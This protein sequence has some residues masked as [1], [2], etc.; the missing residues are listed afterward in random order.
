MSGSHTPGT[1]FPGPVADAVREAVGATF[2]S[3]CGSAP[4]PSTSSDATR[5]CLVGFI[6][7]VGDIEWTLGLVLPEDTAPLLAA[8]FA[9]FEI[10]FDSP[11]MGDVI[12]ELANVL[13]GDVRARLEGKRLKTTMSLP[14]L[15][16]GQGAE[17]FAD[18]GQPSARLSFT[19]GAGMFWCEL[20]VGKP[21][22]VMR[23]PG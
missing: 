14:C 21:S 5:C 15:A 23:M 16:R 4:T 2:A 1:A 19:T 11:D 20:V 17:L 18:H 13:A 7:F 9:G 8:K 3:I 10:P 6:A 12:G 22:E